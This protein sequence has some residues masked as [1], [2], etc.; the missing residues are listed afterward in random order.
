MLSFFNKKVLQY[1]IKYNSHF[2]MG[3]RKNS[4]TNEIVKYNNM[5]L[6]LI[7]DHLNN[8]NGDFSETQFILFKYLAI[9]TIP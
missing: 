2:T 4:D 7:N 3:I 9:F 8:L 6:S 5:Y 1:N